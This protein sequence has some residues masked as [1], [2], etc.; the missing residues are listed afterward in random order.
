M[1]VGSAIIKAF[2]TETE[3]GLIFIDETNVNICL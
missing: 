1:H 2:N 3:M